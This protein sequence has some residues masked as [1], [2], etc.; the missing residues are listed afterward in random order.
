MSTI[1]TY[2]I[3]E[4]YFKG[5]L[6]VWRVTIRHTDNEFI[7]YD[8]VSAVNRESAQYAAMIKSDIWEVAC[9]ASVSKI[10]Q[11]QSEL[12]ARYSEHLTKQM[13]VGQ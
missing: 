4:K 1:K 2:K 7:R 13:K 9:E 8:L 12:C 3:G 10:H 6:K 11:G 5:K